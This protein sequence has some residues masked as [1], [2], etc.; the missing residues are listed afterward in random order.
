MGL[1]NTNT[2]IGTFHRKAAGLDPLVSGAL[3]PPPADAAKVEWAF[4]SSQ[5]HL[6]FVHLRRKNLELHNTPTGG[7]FVI[8]RRRIHRKG[9]SHTGHRY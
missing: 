2:V 5:S 7:T 6:K 1:S 4:Q 3:K 9:L 8:Y